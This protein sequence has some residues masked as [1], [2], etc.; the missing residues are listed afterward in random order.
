[1]PR[2]RYRRLVAAW[3]FVALAALASA[4]PAQAQKVV[5]GVSASRA[6]SVAVN[7]VLGRAY[8][9]YF[10][11]NNNS[12]RYIA[13]AGDTNQMVGG[14]GIGGSQPRIAANPAT[15]RVY[16]TVGFNSGG[17]EVRVHDGSSNTFIKTI[18][19]GSSP[20]G[21]AV[22][23]FTNRVY[24][25]NSG[26]NTVSVIDGASDVVIAT[27]ALGPGRMPIE[28]AVNEATNRVYVTNFG[29][30]SLSVVDGATNT[31]TGNVA[32]P[33]GPQGVAVDHITNRVYVAMLNDYSVAIVDGD[34]LSTTA[35]VPL[36]QLLPRHREPRPP[37]RGRVRRRGL[38]HRRRPAL[39]RHTPSLGRER[40]WRLLGH[41]RRATGQRRR[42]HAGRREP[43]A[44]PLPL[45][46]P[47]RNALTRRL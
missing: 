7:P 29:D 45:I 39:R 6:H 35:N 34:T 42:T 43:A 20:S 19:V 32:M 37:H 3:S 15:G 40:G 22:N 23:S 28:L 25:A 30:F 33:G 10:D 2:S 38:P 26:S 4:V 31:A 8:A 11:S 44:G 13:I 9:T 36:G 41:L 1:M 27:V 24:V 16:T 12:W 14:I 18:T 5:G 17:S 47:S 46:E 21:V